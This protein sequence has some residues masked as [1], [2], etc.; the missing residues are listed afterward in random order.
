MYDDWEDDEAIEGRRTFNLMAK[1]ETDVFSSK[2]VKEVK[3]S[4]LNMRYMQL[5]GFSTPLLI[6]DK[7]GLGMRSVVINVSFKGFK[8]FLRSRVPSEN[9]SV[10]DVKQCVGE[11]TRMTFVR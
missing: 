6:K 3:A 8:C 9:F 2:L 5:H 1:L 10:S 4:E 11:C 7:T